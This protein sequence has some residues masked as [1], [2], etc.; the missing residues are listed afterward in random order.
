MVMVT[1][2]RAV[3][4]GCMA[5]SMATGR[6][7]CAVTGKR[8]TLHAICSTR[9]KRSTTNFVCPLSQVT[10]TGPGKSGVKCM[11]LLDQSKGEQGQGSGAEGGAHALR[12]NIQGRH[13][14]VTD[15]LRDYVESQVEKATM[16]FMLHHHDVEKGKQAPITRVDVRLSSRGGPKHQTKGPQLQK[17]EVTVF[18]SIG[19]V[20]AEVETDNAYNAIDEAGR[21]TERKLR[22]LKEKAIAKGVW[23]GHGVRPKY[24]K[25]RAARDALAGGEEQETE[26]FLLADQDE[27]FVSA[28]E[29]EASMRWETD[30]VV[31]DQYV[32][33][34]EITEGE[35]R[36]NILRKKEVDLIPMTVEDA[37]ESL[38]FLGHD[39]FMFLDKRSGEINVVYKRDVAGYGV[40]APRKP[41]Q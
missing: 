2:G 10:V 41:M 15:A 6:L 13:L 25:V 7:T 26:D 17:A 31:V 4:R 32:H 33:A 1:T 36:A 37:V 40:L 34:A 39:F 21:T 35:E 30:S 14:K 12:L 29:E 22:K 27:E 5:G 3:S 38:Q 11:A 19:V 16:H 18:T 8:N 20:R 9:P 23:N 28:F 24:K